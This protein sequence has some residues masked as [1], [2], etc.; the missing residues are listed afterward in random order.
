MHES[1]SARVART[2]PWHQIQIWMHFVQVYFCIDECLLNACH[3]FQTHVLIMFST[4]GHLLL[5]EKGMETDGRLQ[6]LDTC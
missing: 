1:D 3:I 4:D 5:F 6:T 2:K